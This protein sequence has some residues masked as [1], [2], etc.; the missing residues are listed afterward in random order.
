MGTRGFLFAFATFAFHALCI[1]ASRAEDSY[2]AA[3]DNIKEH[4]DRLVRSYPDQIVGYDAEFLIL[5]NGV[6]FRISDGRTNKTFQELLERPDIDDM[7]YARYPVGAE[8]IQPAKNSDPGR[9][10]FEAL[11]VAMYGDC[12]KSNVT[13]NLRTVNWLPKHG[14]G[15]IA[16]TAVNGVVSALENVSRELDEMP[17]QFVKYLVP[18]GG[19]YNC[20][21]I[22]GSR[23]R[24][25]HAYGAA[26]D[27][28]T[29]FADYWRWDSTD[30]T[31]PRWRNRIPIEIV[32]IFEKQG[33]IW[34]GYC[35][36]STRCILNIARSFWPADCKRKPAALTM[37]AIYTFIAVNSWH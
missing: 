25:M 9:V 35:T 14:G 11:F 18:T 31:Q 23:A 3:P 30:W 22:A 6:K 12:N 37:Q 2:G 1:V 33:F 28:S 13:K 24:S 5:K 26:I 34:G 7:F 4:L 8:P 27:I 29:K 17:D 15:K 19:T 16:I 32:R 21:R 36:I 20:R 10:R